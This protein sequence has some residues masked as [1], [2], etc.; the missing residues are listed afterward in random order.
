MSDVCRSTL[1]PRDVFGFETTRCAR[2]LES[3]EI[4]RQAICSCQTETVVLRTAGGRVKPILSDLIYLDGLVSFKGIMV[5]H[6]TG[7]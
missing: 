7:K 6:H 2:P 5:I 3:H 4:A 1:R